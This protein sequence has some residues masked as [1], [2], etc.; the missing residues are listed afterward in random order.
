MFKSIQHLR[1]D[2]EEWSENDVV[3]RDGEI[4]LMRTA[5]GSSRMKIGNGE[6]KFS[7][8]DT[9]MGFVRHT[10]GNTLTPVCGGDYRLGEKAALELVMPSAFDEDFYAMITF[11]SPSTPTT[12]TYPAG[13]LTFSGDS[14]DKG[15]FVPEAMTHYTLFIWYDGKM[16]CLVRGVTYE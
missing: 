10:D 11:D 2:A 1:A 6:D 5:C 13:V 4:A 8:L 12:V 9:I 7:E 15:A 14:V 16:Q 3:P